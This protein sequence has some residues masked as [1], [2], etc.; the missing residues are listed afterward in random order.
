M[1]SLDKRK[2]QV[3][4]YVKRIKNPLKRDY[5]LDYYNFSFYGG[6]RPERPSGLS[7]LAAQAVRLVIDDPE[8]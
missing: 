5:A 6:Q 7:Y 4:S 2:L 8:L 1:N 3:L